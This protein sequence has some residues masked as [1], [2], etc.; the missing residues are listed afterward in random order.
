[1]HTTLRQLDRALEAIAV[2]HQQ[3]ADYAWGDWTDVFESKVRK[4]M[5]MFC[6]VSAA[7]VFNRV[8]TEIPLNIAV[9]DQVAQDQ[10]NLKD[11]ESDTLQALRDIH[12]V[13]RSSP[14]W[15]KFCTIKTATVPIKFKDKSSE[16]VAGWQMQLVLKMIDNRGLCNLPLENYDSTKKIN[17]C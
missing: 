16:E 2:S 4:F 3:I 12:D 8:T 17:G 5:F 7:P 10:S 14:N 13:I 15:Q 9:M 1:M 6:N 11:V